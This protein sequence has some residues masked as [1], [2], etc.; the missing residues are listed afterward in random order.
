MPEDLE[1]RI[2][3]LE[4]IESIRALKAR[5]CM[6][7]DDNY[8]VEGLAS[9]FTEDAVWDGGIRGKA[10]GRDGIR[11]FFQHAPERLPFAVHMVMNPLIEVNGDEA[12][13]VWYLFQ[14]CTYA[15]ASRRYGARRATTKS[16]FAK[17]ASG[18]SRICGLRPTSGRPSTKAG[19]RPSSYRTVH[20]AAR[21]KS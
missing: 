19:P 17:M 4:D 13:G 3:R 1:A 20:Q 16:T 8:D 12:T 14:A 9:L 11:E 5:Y 2:Q 7:C 18:C 21:G 15:Q 10:V 6:Y